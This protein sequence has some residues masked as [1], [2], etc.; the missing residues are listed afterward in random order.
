MRTPTPE[1]QAVLIADA[2][3][4]V[5]RAT[6]GSGKTW[7]VAEAIRQALDTWTAKT[8]GMAALSFTRVG[9]DE[10]RKA[11]GHD[12]GHPHFV[13]TI[14]AF[15]FRYVIRPHLCRVFNGAFALPRIVAGDRGAENWSKCSTN[16]S[17]TVGQGIKL[18]GCVFID[19]REGQAVVAHKPHPAQSLRELT[20]IDA[21]NVKEAKRKIWKNCGLLTHSDAALWASKI[22][23]HPKL[24][25]IVRAEIIQRFPFLIV[26]ELQDTG[27]FLAKSIRLLLD[28]HAA[29]G[30][31]VG[32]PDQAIY[33]FNGAR[34][35]LFNTFETIAGAVTLPLASSQR[36]S[37]AVA[38]AA[39][40]LKDSA[41]VFLPAQD[42]DGRALLIW[43]NDMAADV[44]KVLQA[45]RLN[46][47][48]AL[49]KAVARATATVEELTGRRANH[50]PSLYCP[51]LTHICRGVRYFRQGK[52]VNA[53]AATR[54]ALEL[55]I[56]LHEGVEDE[57]LAALHIAMHDWKAFAIRCLLKVNALATTGTC[58]EWHQEAG[59][60][61]DKE[62]ISLGLDSSVAFVVGKL[63]PQKRNG[64]QRQSAD[65]FPAPSIG[66]G[67]THGV[68]V[69]TV[70]S[71][72]GETHDVT[73][74]VC[75]P[76]SK[77]NQCPSKVWWS[78]R[79]K[80]REEK[81]IAYVAMT[82]TSG[83]LIVCVSQGCFARLSEDHTPFVES[84][85]CINVTDFLSS[86]ERP[87]LKDCA[88]NCW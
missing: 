36:C 49:V 39:T 66:A 68:S 81:R 10:I 29:H 83:D 7:L 71:V 9:G 82:R 88:G 14:D 3:V 35:D 4:R 87:T 75:P 55:A 13:G 5:V 32:D 19:E 74:L 48:A 37:S 53:L 41:G 65:L 51:P 54:A 33:E 73:V 22:L 24:G 40:H 47:S 31:L 45:I 80:D 18:F 34:P 23:A 11:V 30:L 72:K 38:K 16:L 58:F 6:P 86:L 63:K 79:D 1:Q 76:T 62:I 69:Q 17:A 43:Y 25:A 77:L 50:A 8:S 27:Y 20:G 15:L 64:W 60:I 85:E 46:C 52:N 70:H 78:T 42:R 21:Q 26:D 59:Q 12:L 84:F 44:P 2:R 56:F 67:T 61:L 57:E 28:E